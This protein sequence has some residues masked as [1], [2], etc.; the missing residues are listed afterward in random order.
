VLLFVLPVKPEGQINK[1]KSA[2]GMRQ[3]PI[4]LYFKQTFSLF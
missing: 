2:P 3:V 4:F 1:E